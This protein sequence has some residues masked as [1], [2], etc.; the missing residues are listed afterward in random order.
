MY[1]WLMVQKNRS[2]PSIE[3]LIKQL[4]EKKR[5]EALDP[6][7]ARE[8]KKQQRREEREK[9]RKEI[10]EKQ[11]IE[12]NHLNSYISND[13]FG[14]LFNSIDDI[15]GMLQAHSQEVDKLEHKMLAVT[16]KRKLRK[17]GKQKEVRALAGL[18]PK[19]DNM[20]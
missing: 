5:K 13:Q 17:E 12:A 19:V 4:Q 3:E 6:V 20:D 11:K 2:K 14:Q 7:A 16:K 1:H 8:A 10:L 9:R 18:D 15:N